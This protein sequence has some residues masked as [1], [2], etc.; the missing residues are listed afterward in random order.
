MKKGT[1]TTRD[2]FLRH[3]IISRD[4]IVH[5]EN[6]LIFSTNSHVN[7]I[8]SAVA[9]AVFRSPTSLSQATSTVSD[10]AL[11]DGKHSSF[12]PKRT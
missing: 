10:M 6:D 12:S 11:V 7:I 8:V 9:R 2:T 3:L 5:S 4:G 1:P